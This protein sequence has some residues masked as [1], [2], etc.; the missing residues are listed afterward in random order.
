MNRKLKMLGLAV[1]ASLAISAVGATAAQA[2]EFTSSAEHTILEGSQSTTHQ[3][4]TGSGVGAINCTTVTFEGTMSEE[5]EE[6]VTLTPTYAGCKDN[7]GRTVDVVMNGCQYRFNVTSGSFPTYEGNIDVVCS[8]SQ[9]E[10]KITN[11]LG[12]AFC[13]M[14]IAAQ[15]GI[16]PATYHDENEEIRVGVSATNLKHTTSGGFFNC[17]IVD[18]EH[19]NGTYAGEAIVAGEDEESGSVGIMAGALRCDPVGDFNGEFKTE[20]ECKATTG[21]GSG[22]AYTWRRYPL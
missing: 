20:S 18:G 8:E 10:V 14:S 11:E 13:T 7:L 17:G 22:K 15:N 9:I 4:T 16:G 12:V 3:F 1:S 2:I 5:V 6:E 21:E 19:S